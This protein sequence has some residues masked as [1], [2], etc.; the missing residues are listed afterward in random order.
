MYKVFG[1]WY[2]PADSDVFGVVSSDCHFIVG[3]LSASNTKSGR[4]YHSWGNKS[5]I[6]NELTCDVNR[7][8]LGP[9]R[10]GGAGP[11]EHR[12]RRYWREG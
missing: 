10:Y 7:N 6:T 2:P 1:N 9:I 4:Q 5:A 11:T 3:R 8:Q 12:W